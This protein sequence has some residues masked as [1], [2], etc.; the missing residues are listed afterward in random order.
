MVGQRD[1]RGHR[2]D[3]VEDRG[4]RGECGDRGDLEVTQGDMGRTD[5]VVAVDGDGRGLD[6]AHLESLVGL[7]GETLLGLVGDLGTG[8]R[9]WGWQSA[10]PCPQPCPHV[11]PVHDL[12]PSLSLSPPLRSFS[13]SHS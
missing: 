10:R 12:D 9:G 5:L 11:V 1:R 6:Q 8:T 13:C 7:E 3:F 2:G 4:H